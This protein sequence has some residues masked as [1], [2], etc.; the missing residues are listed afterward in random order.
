MKRLI[1]CTGISIL[2]LVSCNDAGRKPSVLYP[3]VR[4]TSD[5]P[6]V[7]KLMRLSELTDEI[8]IVRLETSDSCFIKETAG[9]YISD[10]YIGHREGG[11]MAAFKLFDRKGRFVANIGSVGQG[12]HEY[13]MLYCAFIDEAAG[14]IYLAEYYNANKLLCYDLAGNHIENIPFYFKQLSMPYFYIRND[15][16]TVFSMPLVNREMLLFQQNMKGE[17]IQFVSPPADFDID[18]TGYYDEVVLS[19]NHKGVYSF[20]YTAIDTLY[21]YDA[22]S[23]R[24]VPQFSIQMDG[25]KMRFPTYYELPDHFLCVDWVTKRKILVDKYTGEAR[26]ARIDNDFLGGIEVASLSC[27]DGYVSVICEAFKL[28]QDLEEALKKTDL[29]E[30]VRNRMTELFN[31][32]DDDDNPVVMIG[33]LKK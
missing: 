4:Y 3:I 15:T 7:G 20:H 18:K 27:S 12:P 28:R 9:T 24:L 10:H 16:V 11:Y 5:L 1:Y 21:H 13:I 30:D 33:K 22:Q 26:Y 25:P 29:S 32:I 2:T 6:N 17:L 14:R 8:E 23:N 31:S 19:S